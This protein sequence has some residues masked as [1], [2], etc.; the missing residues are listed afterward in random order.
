MFKQERRNMVVEIIYEKF[1]I[2]RIMD[3]GTI[4]RGSK[5]NMVATN[6]DVSNN[7]LQP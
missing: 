4:N 7:C 2:V 6:S 5:H 3:I 1:H